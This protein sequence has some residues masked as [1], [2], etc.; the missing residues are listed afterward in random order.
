[1]RLKPALNVFIALVLAFLAGCNG[2]AGEK[3]LL[4]V[5]FQQDQS[6]RYKF[7]SS[8][9]IEVDWGTVKSGTR[10]GQQQVD[11]SSESMSMVVAYTPVKADPY[12]LTT[13]EATCE[14][15]KVKRSAPKGP[16]TAQ[17]DAVENL[18]GKTFTLAV[19]PTG[20]IE[21]YSQLDKLIEEIGQKAFRPDRKRGIIKEPDMIS[22]FIATQWFL[23]DSVSSIE[24]TAEGLSVGQNWQSKLSVPT[25]MVMRKAR[26]VIYTLDEIRQTEKGQLAVIRSSYSLAKSVPRDW[27]V[28]YTGRFRMSGKFGFLKGYKVLDLQGKGEEL[29]NIDKG[30]M[31][32][33]NQQYQ[34][35]L[36]AFMPMGI[37]TKPLITI[38][39]NLTMTLLED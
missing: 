7:V 19:S 1:M 13:I 15:V 12:G 18:S 27:P 39:Q 21:D 32:Q 5:D 10:R 28:P 22:D 23:W 30:R 35:Q 8:R 4:T 16:Q 2:A 25:P 6:L 31:E 36:E 3:S 24:K 17:R 26:D 38:D 20:K 29:F 34:I 11:K 14:S 33:Y 37:D 9:D